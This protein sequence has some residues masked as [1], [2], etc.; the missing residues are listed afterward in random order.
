MRGCY[1]ELLGGLVL[2]LW[3]FPRLDLGFL[4]WNRRVLFERDVMRWASFFTLM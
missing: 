4:S 3:D 2:G 1:G